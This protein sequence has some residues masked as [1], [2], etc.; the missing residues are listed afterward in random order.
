[1]LQLG[2]LQINNCATAPGVAVL[3]TLLISKRLY[4]YCPCL[5][6]TIQVA[7]F[8]IATAHPIAAR[9]APYGP[10]AYGVHGL[11]YQ[12]CLNFHVRA[13][14]SVVVQFLVIAN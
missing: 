10:C 9:I 4:K 1:M 6:L 7:L 3:A 13:N 2:M 14:E 12:G 11:I 8:Q 5:R